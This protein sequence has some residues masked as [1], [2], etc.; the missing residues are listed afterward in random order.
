[1]G[2]GNGPFDAVKS[3][4]VGGT[5]SE[6]VNAD[7]YD[8]VD[9]Y[10]IK[11]DDLTDIKKVTQE[12]KNSIAEESAIAAAAAVGS[13][14]PEEFPDNF[15]FYEGWSDDSE[16]EKREE[17]KKKKDTKRKKEEKK[18][19][20]EEED[21]QQSKLP[22]EI[23]C[24]LINT[25]NDKCAEFSLLEIWKFDEDVIRS[26]SQQDIINA[27]NTVEKSPVFGYET[28]FIDYLGDTVLNET[29]HVVSA[30]SIRNV[31]LAKFD[32]SK[33]IPSKDS[34]RIE[35]DPADPFT[36]SWEEALIKVL[37]G[38]ANE[39]RNEDPAFNLFIN[40]ARR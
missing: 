19:E 6:P 5:E 40:V 14:A 35:L 38:Y 30:K 11:N 10:N 13:E 3:I 32:P 29:G 26:L 36:M 7:Y 21:D 17:E 4:E 16:G 20:E 33:I 23:Y 18:E 1:M 15:N 22:P 25:L 24:D 12:I 28:D 2:N 9:F 37:L 31:W 8:Y 27:I 34:L 39:T